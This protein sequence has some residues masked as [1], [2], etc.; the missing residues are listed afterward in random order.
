MMRPKH[1]KNLSPALI[2]ILVQLFTR[3]LSECKVPSQW[4]TSKTVL[5]YKK[6][7]VLDIGNYRPIC[8]RLTLV[9][10]FTM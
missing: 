5:L 7:D 6:G 9:G 10:G 8:P 4:N 1:L 3:C 2:S